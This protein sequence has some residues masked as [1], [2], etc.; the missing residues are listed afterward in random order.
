[1]F[2]RG[3][4][5]K[6]KDATRLFFCT[7]I[8]G[9]NVCFKKFINA[10]E[11]YGTDILILG[12]DVTGKMVVPVAKQ[13]SGS[14]LTTFA[15]QDMKFTSDEEVDNFIK[16]VSNMGLYPKVMSEAE[17]RDTK[18][19]TDAQEELF[20]GLIK[21]R[22]EEWLSYAED[23][24]GNTDVKVF[25][26]PGNDDF[27][28][29]DEI[30][31]RS[32]VVSLLEGRVHQLTD[33]HEILTT[34]WTNV[35]PWKTERE[36]SEEELEKTLRSMIA[37]VKDVERC[38]F[39]LHCPPHN[40]KIDMCPK[41]DDDMRVV[42][43]MGNLVMAPAGSTAVRKVIEEFQPMVGLH[44]HIHEGRGETMIGR[45]LCINPGSVYSEGVLNG[46]LVTVGESGVI[47]HQFTQG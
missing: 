42:Y 25:A 3:K 41:L 32:S 5:S 8:H 43:E 1:M 6:A 22:L 35:T 36:A 44:G 17:F 24:L 33:H 28:E 16:R 18:A 21:Q 9:S 19:S 47:D 37:D 11:F 13:D 38:I 34:G 45:T 26:A 20:R 7:D 12:G 27:F 23:K 14:Y 4:K 39:N 15:G 29:V 46:V 30:L 2:K 31:K 40:S 10:A